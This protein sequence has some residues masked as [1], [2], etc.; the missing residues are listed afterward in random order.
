MNLKKG[1]LYILG[2]NLFNLLV[3]LFTGFIVPKFLSINT[4]AD[5]KLFQLYITYIGFVSFGFADGI[6]LM[7]GGQTLQELDK[8]ELI[9]EYKTFKNFQIVIMLIALFIS[10]CLKNKILFFCSLMILPVNIG[11][12]FRNLYS[13]IGQFKKYS[14]LTN[15]NTLM[16]FIIN[17][18][19]LFIIKTDNAN[20]YIIMY[21]LAYFLYWI[22]IELDNKRIL[23]LDKGEVNKKYIKQYVQSGFSL[24]IGN[25]C[26]IIFT[27]IDR[28][29]VKYFLGTIQFAFY[30]FS[31]SIE[32]ILGTFITP[33]STTM[34]NY[35][36][37]QK[38]QSK[39]LEIKKI[40]L[41]FASGIVIL[42]FPAKFITNMWLI[43]YNDAI[44]ILFLL[45]AA[46]YIS[47]I[48]RCVHINIYKSEK[49]Q[50]EYFKRMIL[51]VVISILLN[52]MFYFMYP[53]MESIAFATLI[54]NIIWF[55]VGEIDLQAYH[56]QFKE[57]LYMFINLCILIFCGSLSNAILGM[58]LYI[59]LIS[60]LA[61]F[62][63]KNSF[64][65]C[66]KEFSKIL[67]KVLKG[68]KK[69][70]S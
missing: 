39:I 40:I 17:V 21:I 42:I 33:I 10:I 47:I 46:Q 29:F 45:V 55:A 26:N 6:N 38:D 64:L 44:D 1:T 30:S 22:I 53:S 11:G 36:C 61:Y 15:I 62:L 60:I 14:K 32:N 63:L 23:G 8:R 5:V 4:Y 65:Y 41:L 7:H 35:F 49:R 24:M 50:K 56:F 20:T 27:S 66:M 70:N 58:L 13:A 37:K 34:Y 3:S 59:L 16:L 25:F 9:S 2:A 57:Y 48:V 31:V 68:N 69:L 12:Y 18:V 43:K 19:L 51:V 54:T 67:Q 52:G 28:F